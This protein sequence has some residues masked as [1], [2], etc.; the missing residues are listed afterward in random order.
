MTKRAAKLA[1]L[2][3]LASIRR[4]HKVNILGRPYQKGDLELRRGIAFDAE[5]RAFFASAFE[6]LKRDDLVRSDYG[7]LADPE[8][9]VELT[10]VGRRALERRA[11]DALDEVLLT[12]GGNLVDLREGAWSRLDSGTTDSVRQAADAMRE[13]VDQTLRSSVTDDEVKRAE[14][15]KADDT[16]ENGVT[17]AHRA[18]LVMEKRCG[19]A[20]QGVCEQLVAAV[21]RL[22]AFKH[23]RKELVREDVGNAM[24]S[25]EL[26]LKA[27]LLEGATT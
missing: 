16:A 5:E 18:R 23:S 2:E 7:D 6:E 11:L 8:N 20:S 10:D 24:E 12:I 13:L 4:G 9:W 19:E 3:C 22:S 17:R 26:S 21:R 15:F 1:I 27:M 14:W 25:A